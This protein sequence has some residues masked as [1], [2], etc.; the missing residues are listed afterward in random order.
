[1]KSRHASRRRQSGQSLVE[2][3]IVVP[4][5]LFLILVTFQLVLIYRAKTT[6]DY[7]AFQ[8]A[9]AGAV[10]GADHA[11]MRSALAFGLTPLLTTSPDAAGVARARARAE[12]ETRAFA[13][14]EVIAPTRAAFNEFRE[15]QYDGRYALPNDS[16]AFRDNRVGGSQVSVQDANL[17]KIK[18]TYR[19]PLIV[20]FADRVIAGLSSL[21]TEGESYRPASMLIEEPVS[22]HRRLPIESYA[23][24]RMQTPIHDSS[25]LAR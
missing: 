5:F 14:I 9:R 24:V 18:V 3:C 7:A 2:F 17:L 19:L 6:L 4:A 16:L 20:P 11:R 22:G 13:D 23:V 8:A 1:M 21:L 12:L 10:N 25:R 15:R